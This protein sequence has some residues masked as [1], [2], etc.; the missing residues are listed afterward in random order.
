MFFKVNLDKHLFIDKKFDDKIKN[1]LKNVSFDENKA[2]E[3]NG[4]AKSTTHLP[5]VL[6]QI[7]NFTEIMEKFLFPYVAQYSQLIKKEPV[8]NITVQRCWI[9]EMFKGSSGKIHYHQNCNIVAIFYYQVPKNSS[10]LVLIESFENGKNYIE[11]YSFE[12]KSYIKISEGD[13]I[14]H[15]NDLY[16]GVSEHKSEESRICFVFDLLI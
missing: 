16:H 3:K 2:Q 4:L 6:F 7:D 15:K 14:I 1:L 11:D 10:H 12:E 8:K 13:L 9:N 5:N